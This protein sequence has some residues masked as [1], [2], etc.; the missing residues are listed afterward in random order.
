M[1]STSGV[2]SPQRGLAP[3]S[4]METHNENAH[5][6]RIEGSDWVWKHGKNS[7]LH[8]ELMIQ[9][10]CLNTRLSWK[11][12]LWVQHHSTSFSWRVHPA[13]SQ[14]Y[15]ECLLVPSRNLLQATAPE[16]WALCFHLPAAAFL[17]SS[18][19]LSLSERETNKDENCCHRS[20][21]DKAEPLWASQDRSVLH[22]SLRK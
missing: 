10:C 15:F 22:S 9:P 18:L 13:S 3:L 17:Q 1:Q 20:P 4:L 12:R 6:Q 19:R 2:P 8:L 11:M 21:L 5:P 7:Y 16:V 14:L